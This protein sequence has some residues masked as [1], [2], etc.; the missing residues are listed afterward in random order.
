MA[1][2]NIDSKTLE[3]WLNKGEA[4]LIDVREP[5]EHQAKNIKE[6]HLIPLA[7]IAKNNLPDFS[8]K[9][10]VLHCHSGKRSNM[11]CQKL[12]SEDPNLE[13]YNLEGGICAYE[14]SGCATKKSQKN[15]LPLDQQVQLTIGLGVFI[16]SALAFFVNIAFL[17]IPAFFGAGLIF[18]GTT[19]F[20]GLALLMAK[21]PWNKGCK[22]NANCKI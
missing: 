9:K 14:N 8:N 1:I 3:S 10:L 12:L 15:F 11:A 20:C 2:K 5:S 7:Q 17:I 13:I 18:A 6:S 16:G 21:C 4:L 19:G 22:N